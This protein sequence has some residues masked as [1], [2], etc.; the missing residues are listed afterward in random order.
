MKIFIRGGVWTNVEDQVLLAAYMKYGGNQWLRIAS[1]LPRKTASQVKARW[2]EYLDPTLR[3]TPWTQH[4]DEKLLHLARLM[5]MQ[6]RTISQYFGRSAY[7]CVERYKE[8]VDK[9]SATPHYDDNDAAVIHEMMP[10]F[11]T[12]NAVPDPVELDQDEKE[13]LAEAR[14]RLANTQGKKARRK[15]RERQLDV[16]RKIVKLRKKRELVAAGII[17]EEK[18]MWEDKEF[19][20]DV[21]T[22]HEAKKVKFD[23]DIDDKIA[24]QERINRIKKKV[25][26]RKKSKELKS[27]EAE[28]PDLA[29]EL[30]HLKEELTKEEEKLTQPYDGKHTDLILP[31][32]QIGD[33][34]LKSIEAL[35]HNNTDFF[36]QPRGLSLLRTTRAVEESWNHEQDIEE[37]AFKTQVVEKD[38]P[39]PIP[40]STQLLYLDGD[41][42]EVT[43]EDIAERLILE[44]TIRLAY[45]DADLFPPSE[46]KSKPR[47]L[48]YPADDEKE[49]YFSDFENISKIDL[50]NAQ[51]LINDEMAGKVLNFEEFEKCYDEMHKDD[52]K[53][54]ELLDLDLMIAKEEKKVNKLRKM[55]IE[56]STN[57]KIS[58]ENLLKKLNYEILELYKL[59]NTK[60]RYI[61]IKEAE[62]TMIQARIETLTQRIEELQAEQ[63]GVDIEYRRVLQEKKEAAR[64]LKQ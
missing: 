33:S 50:S 6:W 64:R 16:M 30:G 9:A 11:E 12:L 48:L 24:K 31:N 53:L 38:L 54:S 1:L 26:E 41:K 19:E 37:E 58:C 14:A 25:E 15:A 42:K 51:K 17:L 35:R 29:R 63:T 61:E 7:Q 47:K 28:K 8:L 57:A 23:T 49:K 34:E 4:E 46:V 22:T 52:K 5:P 20:V 21:L 44:E 60:E 2:E 18:N 56:K 13:M 39:R 45:R 62:T 36:E 10:N 43:L 32:P 27:K 55:Y 40:V 3:K 59:A